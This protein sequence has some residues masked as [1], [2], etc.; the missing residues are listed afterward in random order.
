VAD[1]LHSPQN[2]DRQCKVAG[3]TNLGAATGKTRKPE[4]S[5]HRRQ[6]LPGRAETQ[7][8]YDKI[9]Y[10]DGRRAKQYAEQLQSGTQ[11]QNPRHHHYGVRLLL[12]GKP[13]DGL[14]V[15]RTCSP[16]CPYSYVGSNGYPL[17]NPLPH[18]NLDEH[19]CMEDLEANKARGP[20]SL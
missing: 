3:C 17:C 8:R 16:N 6:R 4:C 14:T 11:L 1:W 7:K 19:Y 13:G 18:E 5:F 15:S 20:H 2:P 10:Q 9:R 12:G